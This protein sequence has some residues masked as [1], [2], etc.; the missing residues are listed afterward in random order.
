MLIT[1]KSKT[2]HIFSRTDS[3]VFFLFRFQKR[4]VRVGGRKTPLQRRLMIYFVRRW[5]YVLVRRRGLFIRYARKYRKIILGRVIKLRYNRKWI[6]FKGRRRYKK[7]RKNRARK[8][9]RRRRR[10]RRRRKRRR[11]RRRYKRRKRR[12][13]R[14]RRRRRNRRR[15]RLILFRYG[16]RVR[17]VFPRKGRLFF[18][19]GKVYMGFR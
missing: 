14:R 3:L 15:R 8:R 12:R 18:R 5:R 17:K 4:S 2:C 16:R 1:Q 9:R 10:A 13:T 7:L 11:R 6:S 19:I